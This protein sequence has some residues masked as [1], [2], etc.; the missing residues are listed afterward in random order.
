SRRR[1]DTL[2]RTMNNSG[3]LTQ[4]LERNEDLLNLNAESGLSQLAQQTGGAF[5]GG[6]NDIASKLKEIDE[7]LRTYYLLTYSPT[8]Q[9]Y[10]G[11]LTNMSVKGKT[12][13]AP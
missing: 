10:D 8:N 4:G 5:I 1:M 11:K 2:D 13:D 7:D 6:A 12:S 3:P 9:N